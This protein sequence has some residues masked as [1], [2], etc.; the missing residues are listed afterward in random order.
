MQPCPHCQGTGWWDDVK[1]FGKR[2]VGTVGRMGA[3]VLGGPLAGAAAD[4]LLGAVGLGHEEG[5][6][7]SSGAGRYKKA[8]DRH[9]HELVG[10]RPARPKRK[11]S[12]ALTKRN[13]FV[14]QYAAMHKMSVI[15]ASREIKQ[16]GIDWRM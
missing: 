8:Y 2:A 13:D 3:R 4:H 15:D 12:A 11:P 7:V 14:R 10:Y 5:A 16:R 9:G 6:G 1:E